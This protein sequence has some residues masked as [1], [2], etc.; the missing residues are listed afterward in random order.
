MELLSSRT[1]SCVADDRSC[2][3]I[4][5]TECEGDAC[6]QVAVTFNEAKGQYR[7][8]NN[9]P[10]RWAR[11]SASNLASHASNY[12]DP[13]KAEYLTLKS[14]VGPYRADFGIKKAVFWDVLELVL[15]NG[16]IE[17]GGEDFAKL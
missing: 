2:S 5:Y 3:A 8:Q 4:T 6:G 13:G 15:A 17:I 14:V 12:V 1:C 9:S 16:K 7:V 10:D 11:V